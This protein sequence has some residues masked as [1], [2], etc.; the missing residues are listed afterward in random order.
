MKLTSEIKVVVDGS[1]RTV[2]LPTAARPDLQGKRYVNLLRCSNLPQADTSP[3][4][5]KLINDGFCSANG[6]IW[7]SDFYAEGVSGSQTFN[8]QDLQEV[9]DAHRENPFDVVVV[10]D[11]SRLT[12]GGIRHGNVVEDMFRKAGLRVVS[13]TDFIPDGPEGDLIKSVKHY[14]NQ[15]QARS[16]S[17]A[18]ARGLSQSLAK[19][20]RPAAGRNPYGLDREYLGP[21]NTPRMVV[22]WE[23]RTQ[24]WLKPG[25]EERV[26][27][28]SRPPKLEKAEHGKR[29]SKRSRIFKGY[30][31]QAD[32]TSRLVL[33]SKIRH[34]LLVWMFTAYDVW[35]WGYH[36]IAQHLNEVMDARSPDGDQWV[37]KTVK[38]ILFNPIYLGVEVRHRWTG[39]L[40]NMVTEAGTV[41]VQVDQDELEKE[42]RTSVPHTERPRDDWRLV[43]VPHLKDVLP[44]PLREIVAERIMRQLDPNTPA[45]QRKGKALHTGQG[46]H[47]QL[48]SPFLLTHV[49]HSKQTK[50][51]MRGETVNKKLLHGK[52]Q[53][54]YYF[55][56]GAAI[57]AET[58]LNT[59]RIPSEP[60]EQAVIGVIER[61]FKDSTAVEERV[62]AAAALLL[63]DQPDDQ[64][65][66]QQVALVAEQKVISNRMKAAYM[67]LGG[68]GSEAVEE[69]MTTDSAR[70]A[71]VKK[72]LKVLDRV[73]QPQQIDVK[74]V[75]SNVV[76]RLDRLAEGLSAM[77]N[78]EMKQLLAAMLEDM[79]IDLATGELSFS[80]VLTDWMQPPPVDPKGDVEVR[81]DPPRPWSSAV[82][83]NPDYPRLVL[84][85]WSCQ[86]VKRKCYECSRRAA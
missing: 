70:L 40:Y 64:Q 17:L 65:Q 68:D 24:V 27:E 85:Q 23:G 81:L 62:E 22:R 35:K 44:S 52:S 25:T 73:H 80:V 20:N 2:R 32:E 33:G 31:K 7:V 29:R 30:V 21:G 67:L 58:G 5:Q 55:D 60:V 3:G 19:N 9:L 77:P 14:A 6:M 26:G 1:K 43:D 16:I 46:R 59:R 79:E 56:G 50:H 4:G 28:R 83:A 71:E 54:R 39:S 74:Q 72:Q 12:R 48:D 61:V 36:R 45:H 82:E 15:L 11:L 37:L 10:H 42:K 57:R 63:E 69:Q 41:A 86:S 8:R 53:Y 18:V 13:S 76:K 38:S 51:S 47:K 75:T 78:A 49:L 66:R 84:S 34:D